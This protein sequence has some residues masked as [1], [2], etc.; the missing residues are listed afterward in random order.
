MTPINFS[1]FYN[2]KHRTFT[3]L[4][5]TR[6]YKAK[7]PFYFNSKPLFLSWKRAMHGQTM[8]KTL[9]FPF[10]PEK[11]YSRRPVERR[12]QGGQGDFTLE[13]L[14]ESGFQDVN[15]PQKTEMGPQLTVIL[16]DIHLRELLL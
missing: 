7:N 9:N 16:A 11:L 14:P 4:A 1:K 6:L 12:S 8:A 3:A 5:S 15:W 2:R 13:I 10:I